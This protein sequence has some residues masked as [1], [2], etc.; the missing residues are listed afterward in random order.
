MSEHYHARI[1]SLL[2]QKEGE[3]ID[4]EMN[5]EI[6]IDDEGTGEFLILRQEGRAGKEREIAI[7]PEEWPALREAIERMLVEIQTHEKTED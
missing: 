1:L 2:V 5:T 6:R 3:P 7:N 4:G